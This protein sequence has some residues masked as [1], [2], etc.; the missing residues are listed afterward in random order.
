[1]PMNKKLL[2]RLLSSM[3]I[4][5]YQIQEKSHPHTRFLKML[6]MI[7]NQALISLVKTSAP[8]LQ[9]DVLYLGGRLNRKHSA[10]VRFWAENSITTGG[11][12]EPI[13]QREI[14]WRCDKF[15]LVIVVQMAKLRTFFCRVREFSVVSFQR[16]HTRCTRR[17]S[18]RGRWKRTIWTSSGI[19]NNLGWADGDILPTLGCTDVPFPAKHKTNPDDDD[20]NQML[21]NEE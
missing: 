7:S 17:R 3:W 21:F 16:R 2:S 9:R 19:E 4:M 11:V 6:K 8:D 5:N 18:W 1:M 12:I 20:E 14:L 15:V 13:N 10:P